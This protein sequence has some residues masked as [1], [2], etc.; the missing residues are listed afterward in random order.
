MPTKV[1]TVEPSSI[2]RSTKPTVIIVGP[3]WPRSGTAR[4]MQNQ[5]DYYRDRGYLT[6]FVCVPIH[7]SY[8][9][10]YSDWVNIKHGMQEIGADHIFFAPIDNRRFVIGKYVGWVRHAFRGT[11]F[12]WIVSTARSAQLP[13]EAIRLIAGL[14]IALINV[15][16]VF[17]LGFAQ[18]LLRQA[19]KPGRQVPIILET[20]DVQAHLLEERHEINPWTHRVDSLK[21]LLSSELSLLNETNVLV[22]CSVDDFN[23]FKPRLPLKPHVLA[24]PSIDEAFISTVNATSP[25]S[26]PID[27]LFVGQSTDP[28]CAAMKWF[29]EM[30]WPLIADRG[31]HLK[32]VGQV[33]MLVR[34]NLPDV[35]RTFRSNFVGPIAELAP[36][37]RAA[38]CVFAPMVSGTGISIKT[39]EALALG[40]PFVGTSKAYR[41]MPMDRIEQAGLHAHDTPQ[42]FAN[43]IVH[44]L[45]REQ[46]AAAASRAAYC[47]IFS[48]QAAFA[49]R[50][51]AFRIATA[52]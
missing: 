11:A 4:V 34:K 6:V 44:A 27:L 28:N 38:R 17:T 49:S 5:I 10:T 9:E 8:T 35:Y 19:V 41:G 51:E 12:D 15:N 29:F 39:I 40:K 1:V 14:P 37:Y 2:S 20:H 24:L 42:D 30:V 36:S 23:F 22:H 26:D 7:C 52:A 13:E 3:P 21:R 43:A 47:E 50:D 46:L 18:R 33:D 16:H 25:S 48:K 31:Y 45:T 32:I